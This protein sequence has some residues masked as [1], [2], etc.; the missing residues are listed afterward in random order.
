MRRCFARVLLLMNLV[1]EESPRCLTLSAD[2]ARCFRS[3]KQLSPWGAA[4]A[5]SLSPEQ[6]L[7]QAGSLLVELLL[8]LFVDSDQTTCFRREFGA[9]VSFAP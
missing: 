1:G 3:S 9:F 5:G 6:F 8:Q 7:Q 4:C 2:R